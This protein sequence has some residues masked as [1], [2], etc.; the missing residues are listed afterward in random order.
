MYVSIT[1]TYLVKTTRSGAQC[2]WHV[3]RYLLAHNLRVSY[4][5]LF[6]EKRL[7]F[8][9]IARVSY[10]TIFCAKRQEACIWGRWMGLQ[11][12]FWIKRRVHG[13]VH[14]PGASGKSLLK[15]IFRKV[16]QEAMFSARALVCVTR[17][18]LALCCTLTTQSL[19]PELH[20]VVIP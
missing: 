9:I 11:N 1:Q 6:Y 7:E 8:V 2:T 5:N 3:E 19:L 10:S 4:L 13:C 15:L 17:E 14:Q 16:K 20:S 18:G 12:L